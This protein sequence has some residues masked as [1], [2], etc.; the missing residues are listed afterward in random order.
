MKSKGKHEY[1]FNAIVKSVW[2]RVHCHCQT[3]S[4]QELLGLD[5]IDSCIDKNTLLALKL[6]V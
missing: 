5:L 3:Y 1:E 6:I 2:I 4:T